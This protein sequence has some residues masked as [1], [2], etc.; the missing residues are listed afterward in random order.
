MG[1]S[2]SAIFLGLR[3]GSVHIRATSAF[4]DYAPKPCNDGM[5]RS[6][7]TLEKNAIYTLLYSYSFW[8]LAFSVVAFDI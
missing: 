2:D 1:A 3:L 4:A 8:N 6:L 7:V 5:T